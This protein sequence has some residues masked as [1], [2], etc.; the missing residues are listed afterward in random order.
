M[1]TG[2]FLINNLYENIL[3]DTDTDR[4]YITP[5]FRKLLDH[6]SS[7]LREA[8]RVEMANGQADIVMEILRNCTLTLNSHPFLIDLMPKV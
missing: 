4:S 2:T 8:Y 6:P 5:K 1:V 7:K 3:F